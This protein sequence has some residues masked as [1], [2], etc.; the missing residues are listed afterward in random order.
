MK[1]CGLGEN[2]V[3]G[4]VEGI[5]PGRLQAMLTS[6]TGQTTEVEELY[7]GMLSKLEGLARQ[8]ED[9]G[10]RARHQVVVGFAYG[11]SV[12]LMCLRLWRMHCLC[13]SWCWHETTLLQGY[14]AHVWKILNR[15][16]YLAF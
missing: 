5:G 6:A 15:R 7:S 10:R 11:G 13:V 4:M 9:S 8:A 14:Y 12:K 1:G 3:D 2:A 16:N